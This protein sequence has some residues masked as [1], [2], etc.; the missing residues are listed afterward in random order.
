MKGGRV[1]VNFPHDWSDTSDYNNAEN[2]AD[3]RLDPKYWEWRDAFSL[4]L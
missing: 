2:T 3:V 4:N 1:V